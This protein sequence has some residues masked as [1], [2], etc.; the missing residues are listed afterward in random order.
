MMFFQDLSRNFTVSF[1]EHNKTREIDLVNEQ[2]RRWTL[3][4]AKNSSSGVFYIRRG[5]SNFC[6]ANEL[7]QG[8]LCKFKLVEN[9]EKPALWLCPHESGN[10]HEEEEECPEVDAVKNCSAGGGCS[11]E[12]GKKKKTHSPFLTIKLTPSRY[13]TGLLN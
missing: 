4:L 6:Y 5:W 8:D 10:G 7:S 2:G 12:K 11:K 3:V 1:G 13:R 9:G